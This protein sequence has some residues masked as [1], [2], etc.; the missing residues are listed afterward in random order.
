MYKIK[1]KKLVAQ[2]GEAMQKLQ[3]A[4]KRELIF[5]QEYHQYLLHNPL[6]QDSQTSIETLI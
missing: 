4:T 5:L 2:R 1:T 3:Y 6:K